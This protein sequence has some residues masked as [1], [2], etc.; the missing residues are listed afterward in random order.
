M[1]KSTFFKAGEKDKIGREARSVCGYIYTQT[2]KT[3]MT[4]CFSHILFHESLLA[5]QYY[6]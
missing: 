2:K 6:L 1:F 5:G 4:G 3:P